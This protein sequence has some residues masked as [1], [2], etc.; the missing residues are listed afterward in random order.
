MKKPPIREIRE[1]SLPPVDQTTLSNGIPVHYLSDEN[2][3]YLKFEIIFEAGRYQ[4]EK[5]LT[6]KGAALMIKEGCRGLSAKE[7]ASYYDQRGS[8]LLVRNSLDHTYIS[9]V[10][11]SEFARDL[12]SMTADVCLEPKMAAVDLFKVK[13]R[14]RQKL[15]N[16]TSKT[17]VV[18]Y[19]EMTASLYGDSS[20]YGYNSTPARYE[21][22]QIADIVQFHKRHFLQ[23][24]AHIFL[25]GK[26]TPGLL[27]HIASSFSDLSPRM[28]KP[29]VPPKPKVV[30]NSTYTTKQDA[31]Q[32]SLRLFKPLFNRHHPE[33]PSLFMVNLFLGGFFGSRLMKK[34]REDAGLTY[35]IYSSIDTLLHHGYWYIS[36]ETSPENKDVVIQ[37]IN[38][39][40]N[41]MCNQ[42]I[43][44][45]ELLIVKRYAAGQFL[46]MVDGPLNVMKVYRTLVLDQLD[47]Q[48]LEKMMSQIWSATPQSML[49]LSQKYLK[50]DTFH[51]L[52]VG[53]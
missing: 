23:G 17:E 37:K 3:A 20:A 39:E 19:R 38:Q 53:P 50:P 21:E 1:I 10:C 13:K 44:E 48:H 7:L 52:V 40:L 9:F 46:R 43:P 34:I 31:S 28:Q 35:G 25:T 16:E 32:L 11:L 5:P 26:V 14:Q 18:A 42:L 49:D 2:A 4:E 30:V 36:T 51:S 27:D 8:S 12:I 47:R 41:Q 33:Y 29:P 24:K 15:S 22:L 6:S 45:D